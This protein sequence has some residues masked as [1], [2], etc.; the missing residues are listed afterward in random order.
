LA[1]GNR[2]VAGSGKVKRS[3]LQRSMGDPLECDRR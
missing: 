2:C 3:W 1:S